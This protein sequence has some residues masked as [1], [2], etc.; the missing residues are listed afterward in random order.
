FDP[1]AQLVLTHGLV[2]SPRAT[3][4]RASRPAPSMTDGFDVFVQLVMAAIT[5]DPCRSANRW[6]FISTVTPAS[7]V[8][9]C[10]ATATADADTS[11]VDDAAVAR[12]GAAPPLPA[13]RRSRSAVRA[14]RNMGFA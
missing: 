11:G 9:F 13:A 3:A 7:S 12:L 6:P 14:S 8:M 2:A 4:L 1:G 10:D 5:T